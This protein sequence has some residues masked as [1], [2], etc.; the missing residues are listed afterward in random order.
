ME[1]R[2]LL[3]DTGPKREQEVRETEIEPFLL[4]CR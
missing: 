4:G 2:L 1:G 3:N